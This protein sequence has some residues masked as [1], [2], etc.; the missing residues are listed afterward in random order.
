[1]YIF[2]FIRIR[3]IKTIAIN[4]HIDCLNNSKCSVRDI[5]LATKQGAFESVFG[6]FSVIAPPTA[7]DITTAVVGAAPTSAKIAA[8][9]AGAIPAPVAPTVADT[10]HKASKQ[11]M[12]D[13]K[14]MSWQQSMVAT[15]HEHRVTEV[16]DSVYTPIDVDSQAP[17]LEQK[18]VMFSISLHHIERIKCSIFIQYVCHG[19]EEQLWQCTTHLERS[20]N[21]FMSGQAGK[22]LQ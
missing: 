1:M 13:Y 22:P 8:A 7:A 14:W 5:L 4:T 20:C 19:R 17:F 12:S 16:F 3:Y 6:I 9:V 10:F 15:G 2:P 18:K 21:I 11:S